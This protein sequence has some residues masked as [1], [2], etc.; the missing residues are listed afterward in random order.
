MATA[1]PQQ[2]PPLTLLG[3]GFTGRVDIRLGYI[4]HAGQVFSAIDGKRLLCYAT[5]FGD[6]YY[7]QV[8]TLPSETWK[9]GQYF[10]QPYNA[11]RQAVDA[12]G[13]AH[14][15][16]INL[17]ATKSVLSDFLDIY[18][19]CMA[20]AGG[21]V[22]WSITG[23]NLLVMGGKIKRNYQ[24]YVEAL[25]AFVSN[26]MEL[27]KLMPTFYDH[28]YGELFLGRIEADLKGKAKDL[29]KESIPAPKAVKGIIGVFLGK[30][31]EDPMKRM[32]QGI[33]GMIVDVL[34]KTMDHVAGGKPLSNE[35]VQLLAKH[36][37]VPMYAKLSQV[38]MRQDR[39]EAII[40]EA[41]A[42]AARIRPRLQKIVNAVDALT[43]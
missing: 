29:V 30:V 18:M 15:V 35:Q 39:A 40:R 22:A 8:E 43:G 31:G 19:G 20:V 12:G 41:A 42:N 24:L 11:Y 28:M 4:Q 16:N 37:I 6:A 13:V 9:K 10:V 1:Q 5:P 3:I 2:L 32:L 33:R 21:P 23:M 14:H 26:D 17:A 27:R 34:F 7:M 38:P 36:H 25:E